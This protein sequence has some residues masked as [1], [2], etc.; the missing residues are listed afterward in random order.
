MADVIE[1]PT[2]L[3][4]KKAKKPKKA[5]EAVEVNPLSVVDQGLATAY[6][7]LKKAFEADNVSSLLCLVK[8]K[9]DEIQVLNIGFS[10]I[11]ALGAAELLK[12]AIK[13]EAGPLIDGDY[14]LD[15]EY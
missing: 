6:S 8:D 10:L 2:K 5:Q 14:T 3:K 9:D 15:M 11:E 1:F 12:E 7:H 4:P 13:A